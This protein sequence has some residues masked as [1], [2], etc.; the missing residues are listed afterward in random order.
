[1]GNDG[2]IVVSEYGDDIT[3]RTWRT[4]AEVDQ[5][6]P[7]HTSV[8]RLPADAE[9]GMREHYREAG[10]DRG[11]RAARAWPRTGVEFEP[12]PAYQPIGPAKPVVALG[13]GH[14][15]PSEIEVEQVQGA[16][17]RL[18][19][20]R[21]TEGDLDLFN[22][23]CMEVQRRVDEL[24]DREHLPTVTADVVEPG[25]DGARREMAMRLPGVVGD[26]LAELERLSGHDAAYLTAQAISLLHVMAYKIIHDGATI[27]A[28]APDRDQ[29][30]PLELDW[31]TARR[32]RG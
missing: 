14:V 3:V 21:P 10:R 4:E 5:N 7:I 27:V 9:E 17:R 6:E 31:A 2:H 1:M 19:I 11:R 23:A 12:I 8:F 20:E 28:T 22:V 13:V 18:L 30:S 25:P 32:D 16:L 26:S 29:P 15:P 24:H